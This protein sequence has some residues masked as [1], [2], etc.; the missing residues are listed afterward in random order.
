[1]TGCALL[2]ERG[3]ASQIPAGWVDRRV[4]QRSSS[5]CEHPKYGHDEDHGDEDTS[6]SRASHLHCCP[7]SKRLRFVISLSI[8]SASVTRWYARISPL[9]S[10]STSRALCMIK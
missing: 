2:E 9:R 8:A 4:S 7:S 6:E 1:M 3:A 5:E 10:I